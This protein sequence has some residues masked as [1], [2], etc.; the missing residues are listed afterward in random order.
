MNHEE[1]SKG[2]LE[3]K[4]LKI[5]N[6]FYC[7]S[8][9]STIEA[10]WVFIDHNQLTYNVYLKLESTKNFYCV[11]LKVYEV[12]STF[13]IYN[14]LCVCDIVHLHNLQSCT[15]NMRHCTKEA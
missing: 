6:M 4:K 5:P 3:A 15:H 7:V 8:L 12:I 9:R 1:K 10:F 14:W 11:W 2:K 13:I